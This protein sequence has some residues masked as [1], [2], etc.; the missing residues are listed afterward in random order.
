MPMDKADVS[1]LNVIAFVAKEDIVLFV[2]I[3]DN[4]VVVDEAEQYRS[5]V[6]RPGFQT[7]KELV[8]EYPPSIA[9][10]FRFVGLAARSGNSPQTTVPGEPVHSA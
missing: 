10:H 1:L 9:E 5:L 8:F 2:V 6:S 4:Q 3:T 7:W